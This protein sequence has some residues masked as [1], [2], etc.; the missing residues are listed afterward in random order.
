MPFCLSKQELDVI[1]AGAADSG[2]DIRSDY[3]EELLSR[4]LRQS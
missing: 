4:E 2:Y 1:E 3:I